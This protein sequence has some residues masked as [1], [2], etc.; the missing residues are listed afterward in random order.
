[1]VHHDQV[2]FTLG[3]SREKAEEEKLHNYINR[4]RK[5]IIKPKQH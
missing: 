2:G 1:M 3:P 5:S 4:Y